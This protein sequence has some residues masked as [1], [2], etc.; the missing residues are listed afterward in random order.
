[1]SAAT[2]TVYILKAGDQLG[3]YRVIRP[4]GAGGMGEVYLVEHQ[5]LRKRYALKILPTDVSQDA[6]FIDR[7]R[8]EARVMADLEHPGIVRVHNFGE[9]QGRYYLVMDYVS[10]PDGAPRTLDDELAWGNKLPERTVLSMAIQ[11]C[12]AL[13]YAHTFPAGAIIHRDLKPGNILIHKPDA[14]SNPPPGGGAPAP[15]PELR[16]KIADFGL[17]KIVGTDYIRAVI[18]RSTHLTSVPVRN[19][20]SD[21][22][23]TEVNTAGGSTVS[24]LGTYDYMSP[25]QKTGGAIDARSD[26]Y[27]L[28]LILYRMLT[29]HKP[30]GTYD[31][32]S[33][34]GVSRRWD[35]ILARCLKR[36]VEERYPSAELLKRDLLA[37]N[38]P[39][40]RRIPALA[41]VAVAASL[42]TGAAVFLLRGPAP[43]TEAEPASAAPAVE[44]TTDPADVV[45]PFTVEAKPAGASLTVLRGSE[46]V[47]ETKVHGR[48]GATLNLKPGV[49][50]FRVEA[51]GFR[52]LEQDVAVEEGQPRRWS[53]ALE[54]AFGFLS[55]LDAE[56]D[57][58]SILDANSRKIAAPAPDAAGNKLTYKLPVGAYEIIVTRTNY[59]PASRKVTLTEQ[60]PEE[61]RVELAPL[62]GA[63]LIASALQAEVYEQNK[64]I[65][66]TGEW[67][68][69]TPAGT[70]SLQLRRP[71][72]RLMDLTVEVPPNGEAK[73]EAPPLEEQ[74]ALLT[75]LLDVPGRTIAPEHR[76]R[77]GILRVGTSRFENVSFPWSNLV[78]QLEQ[79]LPVDLTVEGYDPSKTE[80]LTLRD[81]DQKTVTLRLLPHPAQLTIKST[82]AADVYRLRDG[83]F[84]QG[85]RKTVFGR[86]VP[87]GKTGEPL[88]IDAF[89]PQKLTVIAPGMEPHTID[90]HLLKPGAS[91]TITVELK[92]AQ[93]AP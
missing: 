80:T 60:F 57:Q 11:L 21:A 56:R 27:A 91:E 92:P 41:V 10:G 69:Q 51:P 17:A 19:L 35:H 64:L 61:W 37:M 42:V 70:R 4:L 62:P 50:R 49:Y 44:R 28:G 30:E 13:A 5:H 79:A 31:P 58:V 32:P 34:Q 38:T 7:F 68:R 72:Y 39:V 52:A 8:I 40:H 66:R 93:Y 67:I 14:G 45:I 6:T 3:A 77:G 24:L 65:G 9:E 29:G 43:R 71:G 55:L 25:E 23:A 53:V 20:S 47:A 89:V 18:D 84:A 1:M 46:V 83:Q 76:P 22:E 12:D 85:W 90:V 33:K 54:E 81:R 74:S 2:K 15:E 26:L 82:V 16:V 59:A 86:D 48:A 36:N 87:I 88:T 78:K 75:V 73:L 63:M